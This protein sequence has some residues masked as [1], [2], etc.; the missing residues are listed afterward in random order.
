MAAVT[1]DDGDNDTVRQATALDGLNFD[2]LDRDQA[3]RLADRLASVADELAWSC[4]A[5]PAATRATADANPDRKTY[6][7]AIGCSM[8]QMR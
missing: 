8:D 4:C 7:Q 3:V 2:L 1:D 6:G 5:R